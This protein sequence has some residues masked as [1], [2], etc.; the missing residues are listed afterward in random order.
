MG[1]GMGFLI[2][3]FLFNT[4]ITVNTS[5]P[6]NGLQ[7][8]P[9]NHDNISDD[10]HTYVAAPCCSIRDVPIVFVCKNSTV[11]VSDSPLMSQFI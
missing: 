5:S 9:M 1:H 11:N 6:G 7:K 3:L 10:A 8:G 4:V 2:Q